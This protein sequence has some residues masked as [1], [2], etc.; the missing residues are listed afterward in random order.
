MG[1][2]ITGNGR[3]RAETA[4]DTSRLL[5][6]LVAFQ[7]GDF[8]VRLP[9]DQTGTTGKVFDALNTIFEM[10]ARM[11]DE[12]ARISNA[13]GKEGRI[14]Q[15]ASRGV[16]TGDW[17]GCV[18]SVNDL[19]GDLVRP[20]TEVARVIG[21][22]AKGDLSQTMA[23]EVDGRP[24]RG[25]FLHTS[26]VVNTMVDQLN[27]FA[28]EVTRVA[29]EVGTEGKLGGQASVPGV[30]GVWKDLTDSVNFMAGNLTAQVRNIAEVATAIANGDLSK[31]ITVNVEGEILELKNTVNTMVEQLNSFAGEV[32]R[33][34][35]EVGTE[36]KLGGQ[37]EVKGVAGV[38]ADLTDSVNLMGNNLTAQ[39]RNIAEVTTAVAK[40]D[41]SRKITVDVRGEIL[42]LKNTVNI[43]VDQLNAFASEVTR[44]AREVGTEGKLGG[45]AEVRGVAGVWADLTDSVNRMTGNLT[46]Q[47]RNIA[48]VTTAVAKGDLS[49]KITVE[50]RGE[51]LEMKN[52]I[53]TMVGQLSSFAAEVTRVAREVGTEGKLGGQADVKD[54]AGT[55]KDLTDS[56]NFMAGNLTNQVRNIA[57]V[58][59]AVAKGDLST[60]I[61]VTARGEILELKNT[62]NTMVDQLNSFASEVT[63]MAKEVGTEGK[64]GGQ[65]DVKGVAGTWRDLTESV[66]SMASNLT[67][68][69]RNIADVTTAVARGDLSRK[70]TVNARGEILALKD[71]I[72]VMVDQLNAFASEVTRV[73]REVGT[74]GRL[75]GQ[76][77]VKGVGGTWKDLTDN[78]N[79]MAANLTNQVRNIAEVTTAVAK[80]DLT[81]KITVDARGE[82][83]EL[84]N[85]VNIM[86]DQLSSFASEVTRVAR[87][88]GT[89]G[90]L[91]GQADVRDVAGTWK[92]LTESVNSMASN[93]TNQ[94]RNI[95]DVTTAVAKGDLSR[96]ITVDVRG[97]ILELKNTVNIMVDQLNAFAGE[98]T[99]VAKEVGT[100]GKLGGQ[101]EVKGV[102]GVWKDLTENVNSMASNLTAQVR[103]IAD[104]TTAVAKGDLSR[105]ITVDVRGE[106]LALKETINTMVDQ[107]S[108]FASEVTRVAR[109]V[110]TEGK[111]GG[112]AN[113]PGVAG[114]WKELTE[115]VNSMASN[116]TNQ[117]RNI[118]DVTTAVARGDLSRK[119]TVDVRGEI[120]SLKDTINTTVDQL[121]AFA[122]EVT[123]VAKEVGT[124]GKLGGQADVKG[125]AGVWKDLTE[126]VNSMASNLTAQV[127]NIA[128]VTTAVAKGDLSRKIT[129][130]V[131][132]E[133]LALKETI[134]VMVD[135]LSSFAAEV[136][137]VAKEVGTEGKL[138]G[139]AKVPG[140]AGTWKELTESVNFMASNLTNQVRNIAEVTTAVARGD[141]SRKITVDVRGEI[142]SLKDTINTMVDQ[143]SSFASE[144]ARVAKDVGTEGKLGGQADVKG[145][146]GVWKDLTESVNSMASNLTAQVRNIADVTTA[147]ARGDLSRKITVDVR[148]EILELKNTINT[149]VDQLNAFASEVTRVAR[150]VGTEGKLGGQADVYG[151]AGTWKDLTESVNLMASNLTVQL[152]DVSRVSVAIASGDLTQTITVNVRG[153]I[154]QIKDVINTMVDRLNAFA[155][156]VT[157]VAREVGTEGKLGGQADVKGV[158]GTWKD[159]TDNV[160]FMA[161][162]LTTQVR[163]IAK[164]VT[165]V[166]NGDLKRKLVLE[167]KGEIAELADT[168]NGMIDT[169][170]TFADQVTTVAREV[171]TEGKLGG[172]ARVPGAAG[173]WKD[174]TDNV[175]QLAANLTTQVRAIA[176]V[177]TAVTSGDLTRSIAV[178]AQGEVAALKDT[179]N[180]MIVNLADTTSKNTD[181]D[182]LKT[183]IARFT[184][185]LQGQ[186][187]LLTVAEALLSDLTPLVGAHL[188]TFYMAETVDGHPVFRL[189]TGY[190]YTE[191][192]DLPKQFAMGQGLVGQCA[193]EKQRILIRNAPENYIRITSSLGEIAPHSIVML[194]V[195]F[196]GEAKAVIELA[197]LHP[198][199]EV[200]LAFLDQLTQSIGILLN[201]IAA[202]MRTEELL[203]QSQ[204]LAEQL[205][206][207]NA[208]LEEKA[209][210]LAEQKTE[211]ETK[212][213]EVEQAK[214]QLEEKAEQLAL[215]SKYKSEFLANMSHEL[216]T[217]LNNLL[218]L[219]TM[220]SENSEK[221]LS[222]RQVRFAETIHSSGT[223]LLALIND[224][225][226]LSKIESGKMDVEIGGIRFNE[227]QDYCLRTFRHVA[228]GKG[229]ELKIELD[230]RLPDAIHTDAKRLQQ[231]LKNL[232]SNALKFTAHGHVRLRVERAAGGWR[233]G[234]PVLSRSKS[235]IAFTVGDTGIGIPRDKQRII[236]EAFQQADGTT[237]RKYGGTGLGLSI[238]RELARLLGGEIALQSEPGVGS[239][240]TLFLPQTYIGAVAQQRFEPEQPTLV[241]AGQDMAQLDLARAAGLDTEQLIELVD[242]DRDTVRPGDAP[243]LI[244]EDDATFARILVEMA[245][246]RGLKALVAPRGETALSSARE[247]R[248]GAI[249]L[250]IGLP[251]MVGW[252]LL[253]R[254]KHDPETRHIPV[255]VISGSEDCRRGL[256][257][258]A[259][260][261][262]EKAKSEDG[263]ARAFG[264]IGASLERRAR[265]LLVVASE[266][267]DQEL[268]RQTVDGDD[269][270]IFEALTRADALAAVARQ[271]LDGIVIASPLP[272][273]TASQLIEQLQRH[274]S[275]LMPPLVVY[276]LAGTDAAEARELRRL[277]RVSLVRYAPSL[278]RLLDETALLLHRVEADLSEIQRRTLAE[279]RQKDP[280]LAGRKVLVVDDDLRNIFALTSLL[281]EHEFNVIHA[282]NGRA[283]VELLQKNPDVDA[284]LMDI[285]MPEM[286]GYETM[287]AIRQLP[288]F[289]SLPIIAL[290]A[291][292]MKGDRE[293]CLEAG[294]S[295]YVTKP[296][297]LDQ[298]FSVLRIWIPGKDDFSQLTP[299]G[300]TDGLKTED[301]GQTVETVDDDRGAI[302]PGDALLL[303][304]EPDMTFAR[305]LVG[306]ARKRGL[307]ALVALRGR[308]ALSLARQFR[309]GAITLDIALPDMAGWTLLDRLKHDPATRHMPVHI[310]SDQADRRRGL[311]LGAMTAIDKAIDCE[312]LEQAFEIIG[313]S[314]ERRVR[315]LLVVASEQSRRQAIRLA[316][317]GRDIEVIEAHS[318]ADALTLAGQQDVD[319]LVVDMNVSD[320]GAAEFIKNVQQK[321]A[322]H[323]PPVVVYGREPLDAHAAEDLRRLGTVSLVRY[324]PSL[325]RLLEQT[326]LLLHRAEADL[327]DAQR[328]VLKELRHNGRLLTG[329]KVLVV[330]DDLR[331]IFALTSL[332]EEHGLRVLHAENGR[333]GTRLLQDHPDLDAVLMDIMMPEMDGYET[334]RAI[335]QTPGIRALP[336][337]ALTAKAM[338]GDRE[339][340]LEAGANDYVTKPVDLEELFSVLRTCIAGKDDDDR[341]SGAAAL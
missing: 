339:K 226:D 210:L 180:Q 320:L 181:Q 196:E 162:N 124:E 292:A 204:A 127:R 115:S 322:P 255:H 34:A 176:D 245:H 132:G 31:K 40:G 70:I 258:G 263:L 217:P 219:A 129:V 51:M 244:V 307:K 94:V 28:N 178:E 268:I 198:F 208:E 3:K 287:R 242:D 135:Q 64:L 195:L 118:A 171:G 79:F 24:L 38:W 207:T 311:A 264:A 83:L 273:M 310:I 239:T 290:T 43:M 296:V 227:M 138:G 86:V 110:G 11:R 199:N 291:K 224:I 238:S 52:T 47:V 78:V 240:F 42:E 179:I 193:R 120:L 14:S 200:Q 315:K 109:D 6:T 332:L 148:G 50:V 76:A 82:I 59:T 107:L 260:T 136:T 101:A 25:E 155:S 338:K 173:G 111:L 32:T 337:I 289:R 164:V 241:A 13:V 211:V 229:L 57:D 270:E 55:W 184:G 106:I 309:P 308:T 143:L 192:G 18:D 216:R 74:E 72:N 330:D 316:L 150:E 294:A 104:V 221:N 202:T 103:N 95:A 12:F 159:L 151:V 67:N 63:R 274:L 87:E 312:A 218:I 190:G 175:N 21:A 185:M 131:R 166:A 102:A 323:T 186:R 48:D 8:S 174:L 220:L 314:L 300:I 247:F 41:L 282:E 243:L 147:V 39:V 187:N 125:V 203:K 182:W 90:K 212:N 297:D 278:E 183:N 20:S 53:N 65:A 333:A 36:G 92:D 152:R 165:A 265:K 56:V 44:V 154:L 112:Q 326:T 231:V 119:I 228:D 142:L 10:N 256:A 5:E 84:K 214:G 117:V 230:N 121:N 222:A 134:N 313:S 1:T 328:G 7:R 157:R 22:V 201:T 77:D 98:V 317:A 284:V 298:L 321:T 303:I 16:G 213:L 137:R 234:H 324:A 128:D 236:F 272:N 336:I 66:N 144:V 170:A 126:N 23:I 276:G 9:V 45:Q 160:N 250:D 27:G 85:T 108:S 81:T 331:N 269:I 249:T 62:I 145:V 335:R 71:T 17:A 340:C 246:E 172:Q 286:D 105:K 223:D 341:V 29:R 33:V 206:K 225:L 60:K 261:F 161:S 97:E 191:R 302:R 288:R 156:E 68:Q 153:E 277:G 177:A 209:Q 325:E 266:R 169:L 285:M 280:A 26:R 113:V 130:D 233:P 281:E 327:S 253:D 100:E 279:L 30:A 116:L 167:T 259:M 215:T 61:T 4:M 139:Q 306:L 133:I 334:M 319:G 168:I 58:A 254:L 35:R 267:T 197:S 237:S 80:G 251:D 189:L 301:P 329:R 275:P 248:P 114:T 252:T 149:M 122:S 141:L 163:G 188:G 140:V 2:A 283:G 89:E 123:R 99:R 295:D 91:G 232:L 54:V 146:A 15:R 158:G 305:T 299:P 19:I 293:K 235:V 257:L 304:V 75:G 49:R 88:V 37:A 262:L 93:L 318:G 69:V 194:P 96:K 73:A 46:A 205:Q 271:D